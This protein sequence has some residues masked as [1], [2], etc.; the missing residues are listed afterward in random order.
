MID[1]SPLA[2]ELLSQRSVEACTLVQIGLNRWT[3]APVDLT[4]SDGAIYR[5]NSR[6]LSVQP[7][8]QSSSVDSQNYV[9][10]FADPDFDFGSSA[11]EG[12]TGTPVEVKICLFNQTTGAFETNVADL[13]V[14]YGG[15]V[16]GADY[17]VSLSEVGESVYQLTC[18]SPMSN[19]DLIKSYYGTKTFMRT[20]INP[21]DSTFDLVYEGGG[22]VRLRWGK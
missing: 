6:L 12:V 22:K 11:E 4:T 5:R 21:N 17:K 15:Y 1:F 13:I 18:T 16:S 19:L 8:Q 14:V 10:T 2:R 3:D 20:K 7:P 9:I